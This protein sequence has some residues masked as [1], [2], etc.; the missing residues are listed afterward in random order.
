MTSSS[1]TPAKSKGDSR[2]KFSV[3]IP[4]Y[5]ASSF[6][7]DCIESVIRQTDADFEIIVVNDGSTDDTACAVLELSD[8][9][10]KLINR[11]NG[12]LA[13]ARNTG[14]SVARGELVAFLDADDR[15]LPDKLAAHR[16]VYSDYP[17]TSV[18]YDWATFI[19]A[20]GNQ[21]GLYMSQRKKEV[22]HQDLMIKNYLGNG[23][24]S[25]VRRSVLEESGG[26]D[27]KL[28]RL[29]DRELWVRL[30][31]CGHK[32]QLVPKVLTE[33]RQHPGSFT[34]DRARMLQGL[35]EF[36]ARISSYAPASVETYA[37][38]A[39][40][41]MHRWMSRAAFTERDYKT[42]RWHMRQSL[43]ASIKILW[44]DPRAPI[45][46]AVIAA[47]S[48]FPERWFDKLLDTANLL[49]ARWFQPRANP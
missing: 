2:P 28:P 13:A 23:S 9:R 33:Y 22:T 49:A 26:F 29:V 37:P 5:N 20:E 4:A 47:Q 44:K 43:S 21:T 31:Y 36:F 14:V 11:S 8:S 24:T 1:P 48:I 7:T 46:F 39:R 34:A 3:V 17:E 12:G 10:L 45:T 27:E 25:I 15:W 38:L 6:I 30:T 41:C 18:T 42:A 16:Q 40:A 35:D 32:I 19:D